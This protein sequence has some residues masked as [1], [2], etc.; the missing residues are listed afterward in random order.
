M[1]YTRPVARLDQGESAFFLRQLEQIDQKAYMRR[2]PALIARQVIPT[3]ESV[4][5]WAHVYT[6]REWTPDG[7]AKFI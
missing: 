4:A 7:S 3:F 1:S 5:E 2:Y 6:W